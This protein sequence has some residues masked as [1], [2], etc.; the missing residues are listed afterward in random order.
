VIGT[1]SMFA[2]W[3]GRL[4]SAAFLFSGGSHLWPPPP[5]LGNELEALFLWLVALVFLSI[6]EFVAA[7]LA[8]LAATTRGAAL[9]GSDQIDKVRHLQ[10]AVFD[11]LGQAPDM[12]KK[13]FKA[14]IGLPGDLPTLR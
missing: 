6:G 7:Y 1:G 10:S 13:M 5:A 8:M 3:G 2:M 9:A 12:I 4:A 11:L 14:T